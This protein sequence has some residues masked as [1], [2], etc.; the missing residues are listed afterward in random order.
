MQRPC[1][2][3]GVQGVLRV[4]LLRRRPQ[5][6]IAHLLGHRRQKIGKT[7]SNQ[8]VANSFDGKFYAK[9]ADNRKQRRPEALQVL[10]LEIDGGNFVILVEQQ[11]RMVCNRQSQHGLA[12]RRARLRRQLQHLVQP[13]ASGRSAFDHR[14]GHDRSALRRSAA[15]A[16]APGA[17]IIVALKILATLSAGP[18]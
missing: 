18:A 15:A 9:L 8:P 5:P 11:L 2:P 17:G 6:C 14:T 7:V 4:G 13:G 12:Q 1:L 3:I 16:F 10:V